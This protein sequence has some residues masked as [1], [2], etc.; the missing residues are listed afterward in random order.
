MAHNIESNLVSRRRI[1]FETGNDTKQISLQ[2]DKSPQHQSIHE[3]Q[4]SHAIGAPLPFQKAD[5]HIQQHASAPAIVQAVQEPNVSLATSVSAPEIRPNADIEQG[6]VAFA[7]YA[8]CFTDD[9]SPL[10]E[11]QR[12]SEPLIKRDR[13]LNHGQHANAV[14]APTPHGFS[15][16][17]QQLLFQQ[18]QLQQQINQQQLHIQKLNMSL[19]QDANSSRGS[20]NGRDGLLAN[21]S[22]AIST[23]S[24]PQHCQ[25]PAS[26][27]VDAKN[28]NLDVKASPQLR[29]ESASQLEVVPAKFPMYELTVWQQEAMRHF[30]QFREASLKKKH[31]LEQEN[32]SLKSKLQMNVTKLEAQQDSAGIKSSQD[33]D[34]R[35]DDMK[36]SYD[37]Q[38]L[39]LQACHLSSWRHFY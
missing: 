12:L 14:V 17:S 24:N 35:L 7:D 21:T 18:Q 10:F 36:M 31:M 33:V 16:A 13:Q 1:L 26:P 4:P 20:G 39:D 11:Q 3:V 6:V 19:F 25:L 9:G 2:H 32:A 37:Q 38:I 22:M 34:R 23:P 5:G 28:Y 30:L 8:G 27:T 29:P 15:L